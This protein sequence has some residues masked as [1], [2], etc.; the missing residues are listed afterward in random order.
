MFFFKDCA[1]YHDH[2]EYLYNMDVLQVESSV[3][4]YTQ[5][6]AVDSIRAKP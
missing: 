6:F 4:A 1:G 2:E 5:Y 3:E